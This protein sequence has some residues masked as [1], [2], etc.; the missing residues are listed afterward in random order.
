VGAG[1][2][3]LGSAQAILRWRILSVGRLA[4][5]NVVMVI[6]SP[7]SRMRR[8]LVILGATI[9]VAVC[10]HKVLTGGTW[11]DALY[12]V[13]ITISS[14][15]FTETSQLSPA[16]QVYFILLILV[17]MSAVGYTLGGLLQMMTA[18]E[19]QR[20]MELR[21]M[22]RDISQLSG[23]V[24]LC[25]YGRMGQILAAELKR[26]QQPL[27]VLERDSGRAAECEEAGYLTIQ[28]DATEESQLLAAGV[29][30]AKSLVA[31]LPSDADCVFIT[32]TARNLHPKLLIISRAEHRS[33]QK[34]LVQAGAD[35]VVM[36]ATI[37]AQRIATMLT[38]PSTVELFELVVD[39]AQLD[40]E[41]DE[42]TLAPGSALVG[43][44]A[45]E[46]DARRKTGLLIVAIKLGS[47]GRGEAAAR[48]LFNPDPE[49]RFAA[50]DTLIV[51][52]AVQDIARF[53]EQFELR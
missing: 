29:E 44:T 13:M 14:V 34:K 43:R 22:S 6:Q 11:L 10:A 20:A 16:L 32:L 21:R 45:K 27:V 36:P 8:G 7:L 38:R 18:G 1:G 49:H 5:D 33:S 51:M 39:R 50:G 46:L 35:R 19:L 40:V 41:V 25:G 12:M 24:I 53:R 9:V 2:F 26:Q 42:L 30:R 47:E 31:A 3:A 28:G 15:G 4:G 37:G 17:G 52:G 23:H 48:M